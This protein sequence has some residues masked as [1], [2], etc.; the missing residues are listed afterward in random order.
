MAETP[1]PG[2]T[3]ADPAPSPSPYPEVAPNTA[4]EETPI[5]PATPDDGRPYDSGRTPG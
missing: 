4:P 1:E 2:E 5:A 3:P